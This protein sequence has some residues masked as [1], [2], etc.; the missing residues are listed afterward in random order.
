[1]TT[2]W[3]AAERTP[4]T[5]IAIAL[6]LVV[7]IAIAFL[8]FYIRR[9]PTYTLTTFVPSVLAGTYEAPFIY[10]PLAPWLVLV[11][12]EASGLSP[13]AAFVALR[14]AGVF[15]ALLTFHGYLRTWHSPGTSLAATL[16]MAA[17]LPLTMTNSWPVPGT[18]LEL[19]LFSLGCMAIAR[20]MERA[21]GVILVVALL[22]RE[23]SAFLLVLWVATR[24]HERPLRQWV[25]RGAAFGTVW[26]AVFAGIRWFRGFKTYDVVMLTQNLP[27]LNF[28]DSTIEP[29]LRLFGWFWLVMLAAPVG[30]AMRGMMRPGTPL[31]A[32]QAFFVGLVFVAASLVAASIVEPRVL[33]PAFPLFAP[34][35]LYAVTASAGTSGHGVRRT[36][37][38]M[39]A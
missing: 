7:A 5:W 15:A 31:F 29:R 12:T 27:Y 34:A 3:K 18:Y 25:P 4:W 21:F 36:V 38:G 33:V 6:Y 28:L 39:S 26:L 9:N 37:T 32:R 8:D 20:R 24:A 35:A 13:V 23:T 11:F 10:R 16:A 1:V 22:N 14:L 30:L 2:D 19:A 17:L